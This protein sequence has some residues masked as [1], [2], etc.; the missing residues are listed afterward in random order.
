MRLCTD[1]V[2]WSL[3]PT[4]PPQIVVPADITQKELEECAKSRTKGRIPILS[5]YSKHTGATLWRSSQ[6]KEGFGIIGGVNKSHKKMLWSLSYTSSSSGVIR[7][8]P[9]LMDEKKGKAT[10]HIYD[11]RSKMAAIGNKFKGSGY[12][13]MAD[14]DFAWLKFC[15]IG[16]IHTMRDS[17]IKMLALCN[18]PTSQNWL[19]RLDRSS[20]LYHISLIIGSSKEMVESINVF[21]IR[22]RIGRESG[23]GTL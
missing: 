9:L 11:A 6:P 14:Y 1:N 10:L 4:Y 18:D 20:W 19:E 21:V 23:V 16:N 8:S 5:Y 12:E 22:E 2:D 7:S 3:C 13:N 17:Y 15:D